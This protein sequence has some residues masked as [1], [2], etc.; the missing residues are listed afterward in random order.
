[1]YNVDAEPSRGDG[2]LALSPVS[3]RTVPTVKTGLIDLRAMPANSWKLRMAR[4]K[5]CMQLVLLVRTKVQ[6][7]CGCKHDGFHGNH[8]RKRRTNFNSSS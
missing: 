1:M 5:S 8:V 2:R 6:H 7:G 4:H 3:N